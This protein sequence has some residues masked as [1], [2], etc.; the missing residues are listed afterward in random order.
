MLFFIMY[1]K[2]DMKLCRLMLCVWIILGF[3]ASKLNDI[4]D[5]SNFNI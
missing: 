2:P 3:Y 1:T 5:T 4:P